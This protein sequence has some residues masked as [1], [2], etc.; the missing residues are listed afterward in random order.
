[1]PDFVSLKKMNALI[2][3]PPRTG[4]STLIG[5]LCSML[6]KKGYNVGGIVTP[7]IKEKIDV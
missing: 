3:A 1:M 4:K 2:Q 5:K 7:E 6:K